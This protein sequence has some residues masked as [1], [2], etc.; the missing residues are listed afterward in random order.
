MVLELDGDTPLVLCADAATS[1]GEVRRQGGLLAERLRTGGVSRLM[2]SSDDPARLLAA[3]HGASHVGADLWIVSGAI[4]GEKLE[5]M[6]RDHGIGMLL[7]DGGECEWDVQEG[8]ATGRVCLLTSGT[9]GQPKIV[10]HTLAN[11][12]MRAIAA[13]GAATG[14]GA[15]WLLTYQPSAFAGM[16]VILTAACTDATL[17][18]APRR[19]YDEWFQAARRHRVTHI[20]GTPTFWRGLLMLADPG[21]LPDLKQATLGGEAID[22]ATLNRLRLVCPHARI[23]HIYAST[24][25][26]VVFSVNDGKAGFPAAWLDKPVQGAELRIREGILEVRTPCAML[27]YLSA[28]QALYSSDGWFITGDQVE[29]SG[30][31]VRF[32]GR[33]DSVVNVGG[34]KVH[35]SVVESCLLACENVLEARVYGQPNPITGAVLCADL[36]VPGGIDRNALRDRVVSRCREKL[37]NF[38]V[39][40]VWRFVDSIPISLSGKK[41]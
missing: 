29:V 38:E 32:L 39:P 36:V 28:H 22:Q 16:Q 15:R 2:V 10:A 9:T 21:S 30:D 3:L 41:G 25:A 23:T 5:A 19:N 31:R 7:T 40:R 17:V 6:A 11:L 8:G 4:A 35:P 24:E 33:L 18:A 13:A 26:G 20:S 14:G 27:G 12:A 37:S 34:L 1:R